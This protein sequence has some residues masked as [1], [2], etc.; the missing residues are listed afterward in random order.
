MNSKLLPFHHHDL[1]PKAWFKARAQSHKFP[2]V[3]I[4]HD[5]AAKFKLEE[6]LGRTSWVFRLK[7]TPYQVEASVYHRWANPWGTGPADMESGVTLKG[8]S[9][10]DE[11]DPRTINGKTRRWSE[12]FTELFP[13]KNNK[14]N[15]DLFISYVNE[16]QDLLSEVAEFQLA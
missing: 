13:S 11:L 8:V 10:D 7:G 5:F 14:D 2:Q 12:D 1:H 9:W 4:S 3:S 16:V 6:V 15:I